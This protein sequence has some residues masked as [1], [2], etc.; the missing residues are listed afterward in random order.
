[1]DFIFTVCDNA[2]GETCPVWPGHPM[3]AHW[4]IE[5]PAAVEGL[6]IDK[7]RAFAFALAFRQLRNRITLF[8]SLPFDKLDDLAL[9]GKLREIGQG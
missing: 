5:D 9:K 4:G 1:M 2:A 6:D 8:I 7:E 3:T